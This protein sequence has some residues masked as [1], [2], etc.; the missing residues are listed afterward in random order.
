MIYKVISSKGE[1]F[2][3]ELEILN[4]GLNLNN[5]VSARDYLEFVNSNI[6]HI[7]LGLNAKEAYTHFW[8][9]EEQFHSRI[10]R[11]QK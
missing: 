9:N 5:P 4:E 2:D 3:I 1:V 7:Q 11:L 6:E 8:N 10:L